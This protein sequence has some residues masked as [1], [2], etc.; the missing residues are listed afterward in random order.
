MSFG[1][2]ITFYCRWIDAPYIDQRRESQEKKRGIPNMGQYYQE[3]SECIIF[4]DGCHINADLLPNGKLPRWFYRSWTLQ[5][6]ILAR[7]KTF[8]FN[9]TARSVRGY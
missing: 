7:K 6:Y 1:T 9:I 3:A 5:E 8:V 4:P 2:F